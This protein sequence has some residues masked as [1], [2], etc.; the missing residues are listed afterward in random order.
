MVLDTRELTRFIAVLGPTSG[1]NEPAL[2][3]SRDMGAG[4]IGGH[5]RAG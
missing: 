3:V 5:D 1:L 4:Q 2:A